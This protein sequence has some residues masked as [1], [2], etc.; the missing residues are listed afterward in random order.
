MIDPWSRSLER[1][2]GRHVAGVARGDGGVD[3]HQIRRAARR[4]PVGPPSFN[5]TANAMDSGFRTRRF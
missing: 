5:P 1:R 2:L 3:I 4:A